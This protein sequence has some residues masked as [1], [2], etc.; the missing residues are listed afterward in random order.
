MGPLSEIFKP[1]ELRAQAS[2]SLS[3]SRMREIRVSSSKTSGPAKG[4]FW[5]KERDRDEGE[6]AYH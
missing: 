6:L 1:L 3:K 4:V 2:I 5:D